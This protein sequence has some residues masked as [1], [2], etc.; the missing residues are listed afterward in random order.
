MSPEHEEFEELRRLLAIKR[1]EQPPP[2][3]FNNFSR[4]VI[5]RIKAGETRAAD[6]FLERL[7][8][9]VPWLRTLWEGFEAKPIVAGAFGVGVCGLLVVG[10]VSSERTDSTASSFSPN[11]E[12]PQ[13]FFAKVPSNQSGTGSLFDRGAVTDRAATGSVFT[14]QTS[15]FDEIKPRPH[16]ELLKFSVPSPAN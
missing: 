10:L 8:A 16:V 5:A 6:S 12:V 2:G 1:H 15:I 7:L 3:Y 11:G 14:A 4:Q 9:R 13:T